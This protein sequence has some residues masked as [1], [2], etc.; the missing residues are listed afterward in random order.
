MAKYTKKQQEEL[1]KN[2]YTFKVQK[3]RI[4]FTKEFKQLFWT[5]YQ[6]GVSPRKAIEELGYDLKYFNQNQIDNL[7]QHLRK[8]SIAG[9]DFPEGCSRE[10]RPKIAPPPLDNSEQS[11]QYL[12]HEITYLR[13]EVEFLKKVLQPEKPP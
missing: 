11:M 2:K 7:V 6:A 9:E 1:M 3:D 4:F 10:R 12:Q 5:K 13:Q 8:K